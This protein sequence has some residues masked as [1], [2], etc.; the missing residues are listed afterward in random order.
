MIEEL[1]CYFEELED[2]ISTHRDA[3]IDLEEEVDELKC[4]VKK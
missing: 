1:V 3:I 2:K 4:Q